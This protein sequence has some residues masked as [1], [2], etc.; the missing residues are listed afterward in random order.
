MRTMF[1]IRNLGINA[2]IVIFFTFCL[3]TCEGCKGYD[4]A[5]INNS[6]YTLYVSDPLN[7]DKYITLKPGRSASYNL[8]EGSCTFKAY[9]TD[10]KY[11]ASVSFRV[12]AVANDAEVDGAYYDWAVIFEDSWLGGGYAWYYA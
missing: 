6:S 2:A 3:S 7:E 1:W 4:G 9:Y 8:E 11:F 10:W 5:I 12:N